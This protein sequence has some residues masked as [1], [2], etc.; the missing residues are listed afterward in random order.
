MLQAVRTSTLPALTPEGAGEIERAPAQYAIGLVPF[1][2]RRWTHSLAWF[3]R[4]MELDAGY[5]PAVLKAAQASLNL[6]RTSEALTLVETVLARDPRNPE[7]LAISAQA[8]G[9]RR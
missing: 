9:L 1:S 2:Q 8:S 4:A 5:T 6:G 3:R 7:A